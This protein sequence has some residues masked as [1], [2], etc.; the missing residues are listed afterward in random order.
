MSRSVTETAHLRPRRWRSPISA[1]LRAGPAKTFIPDVAD[2]NGD[3]I[4]DIVAFGADGVEVAR[5]NANGTF[6]Q[7]TKDL[8]QFGAFPDAGGWTSQDL[9]PRLLGDINGDGKAD[10]V[11]FGSTGVVTSLAAVAGA[12]PPAAFALS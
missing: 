3:G 12:L 8:A 6:S 10:V 9:Y 1:L 2:V 7:P 4:A 11:G 5:G